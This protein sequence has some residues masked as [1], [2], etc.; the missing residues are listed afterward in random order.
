MPSKGAFYGVVVL[1]L[2]LLIISS[3]MALYYYGEGLQ[4]SSQ[5]QKYVE[6]LDTALAS[7]R[8]LSAKYNASLSDYNATLSLLAGAVANLNTTAPA[9]RNASLE[10][11]SLWNAYQQLAS[12]SGRRVLA[13]EV[14]MLLDFGNGT[15]RWYNDSAAQPGWNGYVTTL[16][17][18]KGNVQAVWYPAGSFGPG[19]EGEHFVTGLDG[20]SQTSS[21]YWGIWQ[22]SGGNWSYLETGAD[23]MEIHNGTTFAWALCSLDASYH[24]TCTP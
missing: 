23:L 14:N 3:S 13:Y 24:P 12:F 8:S 19:T 11:S 21:A 22:F 20:V 15:S 9:Y 16:V 18:L 4:T 10:L 1:F 5:N 17:L 2:A 7:Y 6:E